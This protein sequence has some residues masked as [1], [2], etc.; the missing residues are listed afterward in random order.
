MLSADACT[1]TMNVARSHRV[2]MRTAGN[3]LVDFA[4]QVGTETRPSSAAP[5]GTERF[6]RF[7]LPLNDT[8]LRPESPLLT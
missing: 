4:Q 8:S 5:T 6:V 3:A 2:R 1:Q 7:F